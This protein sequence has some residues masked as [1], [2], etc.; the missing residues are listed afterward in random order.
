[1][2]SDANAHINQ[3]IDAIKHWCLLDARRRIAIDLLKSAQ[4]TAT[5][6]MAFNYIDV[7]KDAF[8][9][10]DSPGDE[11]KVIFQYLDDAKRE[12]LYMPE[13]LVKAELKEVS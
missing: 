3:A 8:Y 13:P 10:G 9:R 2:R 11:V 4:T 1:M 7:A 6:D 12:L 5:W